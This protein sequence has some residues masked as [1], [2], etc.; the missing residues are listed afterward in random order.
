MGVTSH[1][2][3]ACRE[4]APVVPG[5]I[6][7]FHICRQVLLGPGAGAKRICGQFL[8]VAWHPDILLAKQALYQLSYAPERTIF[9][10]AGRRF[11]PEGLPRPPWARRL[12]G[13]RRG[14]GSRVVGSGRSRYPYIGDEAERVAPV[15]RSH[16]RSVGKELR[17]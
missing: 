8:R 10:A 17:V 13:R 14:A 6:I 15:G 2:I 7:E 9:S 1:R 16:L 5:R 12:P 4:I 3:E 11:F